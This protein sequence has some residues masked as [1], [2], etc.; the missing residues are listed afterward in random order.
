MNLTDTFTLYTRWF[1][2]YINHFLVLH[3][4]LAENIEIKA[5]HSRKVH[6]EI[7]G[8]AKRKKLNH[9]L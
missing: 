7:V 2:A 9:E 8:L 5:D 6:A 4:D 3:S 1:S